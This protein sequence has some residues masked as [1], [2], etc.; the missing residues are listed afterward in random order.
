MSIRDDVREI[1]RFAATFS[2]DPADQ[3]AAISKAQ[4]YLSRIKVGKEYDLS[5]NRLALTKRRII[6]RM[7]NAKK[8]EQK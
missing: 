7:K 8:K 5:L 6:R 3:L 4:A 1:E 2:D